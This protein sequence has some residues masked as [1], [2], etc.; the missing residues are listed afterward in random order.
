H[1][2]VIT[3]YALLRRDLDRWRSIPLLAAI[4]DEAQTIKNP[5]ASVSRAVLELNA[6]NRLALTGTPIENRAL[7]LW[8]IMQFVN[9]GYLGR[10]SV[11][12][13]RYDRPDTP[14]HTRRLLA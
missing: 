4:L 9:P 11:F 13:G 3:T 6:R 5:N 12:A 7:D 8:S 2:V 14:P 10:R 1:D